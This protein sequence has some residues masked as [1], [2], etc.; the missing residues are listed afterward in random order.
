MHYCITTQL[1]LVKFMNQSLVALYDNYLLCKSLTGKVV[2]C[3]IANFEG[4]VIF[5]RSNCNFCLLIFSC[6]DMQCNIN[7]AHSNV[8]KELP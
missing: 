8:G 5:V 3:H 2:R 1:R 7:G 6:I 4:A